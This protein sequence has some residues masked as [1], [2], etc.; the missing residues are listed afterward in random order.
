MNAVPHA[1]VA[2]NNWA[3]IVNSEIE[4]GS[5]LH[6]RGKRERERGVNGIRGTA[7]LWAAGGCGRS[8]TI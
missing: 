3:Y 5:W 4:S 1:A 7:I 8:W 2:H 6:P